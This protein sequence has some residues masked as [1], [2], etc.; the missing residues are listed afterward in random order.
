MSYFDHF[1]RAPMTPAGR[2]ILLNTLK[3]E[4]SVIEPML[5]DPDATILEI[6]PGMGE[7]AQYFISAGYRNYTV[8]EPNDLMRE[9][10]ARQ[11][12][13]TKNYMIPALQEEDSSY[14][15]IILSDVF[16]HLNDTTE[17]KL[18]I[19]EARRVLRPGG[20]LCIGSPDYTHWHEDFFNA[21]FSHSNIT[22][23]RRTQQLFQNNGFRTLKYEYFSGFLTG[24]PATLLSHLVHTMLFFLHSPETGNK[25]YKLKLT[26][27][28]RFLIVGKKVSASPE[29]HSSEQ[30]G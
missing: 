10:L 25:L 9:H 8:V 18:F 4:F 12:L 5:P 30:T 17:A 20:I 16:E 14:D 15:A 3:R 2:W 21:D 11:S 1:A 26:F 28:R 22:S 6:G 24:F 13:R 27:L 19:A 29:A 7:L 23:V